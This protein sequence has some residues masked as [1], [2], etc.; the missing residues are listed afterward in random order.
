MSLFY[1][2]WYLARQF[3]NWQKKTRIVY[4]NTDDTHTEPVSNTD[5]PPQTPQSVLT[6]QSVS[7]PLSVPIIESTR[8]PLD[9]DTMNTST[10]MAIHEMEDV[11]GDEAQAVGYGSAEAQAAASGSAE[12]QAEATGVDPQQPSGRKGRG[13]KNGTTK[14]RAAIAKKTKVPKPPRNPFRRSETGKLQLKSL[15]MGKRVETMTP[16]VTLLRDRLETMESRLQFISGKLKLVNE[17]LTSREDT[18][19]AQDAGEPETA[20]NED[21]QVGVDEIAID[22]VIE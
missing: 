21:G 1:I 4:M 18:T 13:R 2:L 3:S 19:A 8:N 17:E 10:S 9:M 12:A 14:P 15:Q 5:I 16:R 6:T 22:D 7:T 11:G 20:T